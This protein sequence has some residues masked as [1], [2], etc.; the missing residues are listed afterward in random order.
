MRCVFISAISAIVIYN[1]FVFFYLLFNNDEV[2]DGL[3]INKNIKELNEKIGYDLSVK[4]EVN[5][6]NLFS[7]AKEARLTGIDVDPIF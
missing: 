6:S 4:R 5:L 3:F 1:I 7:D 2:L